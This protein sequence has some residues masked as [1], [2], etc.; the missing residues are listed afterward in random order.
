M[1]KVKSGT[2]LALSCSGYVISLNFHG[3]HLKVFYQAAE[4]QAGMI[5]F[6]VKMF[7]NLKLAQS[8]SPLH[9]L[10]FICKKMKFIKMQT[11][12]SLESLY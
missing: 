7:L 12:E 6:E 2:K 10:F 1:S 9:F 4:R 8:L 3:L 5:G 11:L